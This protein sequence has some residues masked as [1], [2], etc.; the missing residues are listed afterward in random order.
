MQNSPFTRWTGEC[1]KPVNTVT[2]LACA[3]LAL[4]LTSCAT[5]SPGFHNTDASALVVD[6]LDIRTARILQPVT[7]ENEGNDQVL[8]AA[9]KL[10]QHQ[11]A[12]VILENYNEE[13]LGDEFRDRS[14]PWLV[15]L[16]GLGYE[17][18]IFLQGL[19]VPTAEGLNTLMRYD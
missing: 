11:T 13:N 14:M 2:F 18:I 10:P 19:G 17:H 1:P 6:A 3:L 5:P 9:L 8:A 16:K 7:S 15:G 4:M 12:V